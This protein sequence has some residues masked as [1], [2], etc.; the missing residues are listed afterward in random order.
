MKITRI[1]R[2]QKDG[3]FCSFCSYLRP[4]THEAIS[5]RGCVTSTR[6]CCGEQACQSKAQNSARDGVTAQINMSI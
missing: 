6:L 2:N 1:Q 5:A 4:A 3:E